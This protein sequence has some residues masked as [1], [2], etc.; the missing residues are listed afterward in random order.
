MT[1]YPR[2]K[3]GRDDGGISGGAAASRCVVLAV[4][5]NEAVR[6]NETGLVWE[7][8]L[9]ASTFTWAGALGYCAAN[10]LRKNPVH[11]STSSHHERKK[12][13]NSGHNPFALSLSKGTRPVFPH[14]AKTK[15]VGGRL[16]WR[17]PSVI[18][19]ASLVDPSQSN[20][21]LP[22]CHHFNVQAGYCRLLLVGGEGCSRSWV[23]V[24][25]DFQFCRSIYRSRKF[26]PLYVVCSR[27][28]ERE[29]VLE[30]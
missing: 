4:F 18:E 8:M 28:H 27:T 21:N 3:V 26:F 16:G 7:K 1:A 12:L 17:F 15:T 10:R 14:P 5:N 11:G 22:S 13:M 20:P 30:D 23:R 24:C 25:C 29:F 2:T 19:L 6:D 9:S